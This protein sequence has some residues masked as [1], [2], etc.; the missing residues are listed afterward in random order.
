M[1]ILHENLKQYIAFRR[2]LGAKLQEP[3]RT[4]GYFVKFLEQEGAEFITLEPGPPLGDDPKTRAARYLGKAS[5]HGAAIR[6]LA[7]RNRSTN[8]GAA[9]A[10]AARPATA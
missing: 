7:E 10:Y 6:L 5:R 8:R 3:A 9:A 4:L 1:S 2:A